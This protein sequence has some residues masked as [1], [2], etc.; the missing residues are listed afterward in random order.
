M[1]SQNRIDEALEMARANALC[2][3]DQ[4]YDVEW[5]AITRD[6]VRDTLRGMGIHCGIIEELCFR[7]FDKTIAGV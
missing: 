4:H 3:L 1:Y 6:N 7:L 2:A 5:V